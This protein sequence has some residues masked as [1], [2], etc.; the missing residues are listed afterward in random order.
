AWAAIDRP[1]ISLLRIEDLQIDHIRHRLI[2]CIVR[3]QMISVIES[4]FKC[5][6]IR[7][8]LCRLIEIH[9]GIESSAHSNPA[10]D[11]LTHFLAFLAEIS[12]SFIRRESATHDF[13]SVSMRAI[14][15]LLH[16]SDQFL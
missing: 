3:V 7:R 11:G 15:H 16:C 9:Y 5:F 12:C 14:D 8:I 10:V 4:G 6:G 13:Y 1:Y 2:P